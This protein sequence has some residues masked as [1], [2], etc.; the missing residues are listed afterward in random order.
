[1]AQALLQAMAHFADHGNFAGW[2][3]SFAVQAP[4]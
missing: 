1:M 4:A 2:G 3:Q